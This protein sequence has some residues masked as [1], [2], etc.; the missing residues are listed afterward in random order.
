MLVK[1]QAPADEIV[2]HALPLEQ[3]EEAFRL[4]QGADGALKVMLVP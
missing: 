3:F 2:T 1:G 4:A